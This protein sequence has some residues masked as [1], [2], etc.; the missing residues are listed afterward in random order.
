MREH[1]NRAKKEAHPLEPSVCMNYT[2][3]RSRAAN[4]V[5]TKVPHRLERIHSSINTN[6]QEIWANQF[7]LP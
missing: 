6:F 5:A 2:Q 1:G 3:M 7:L 4:R